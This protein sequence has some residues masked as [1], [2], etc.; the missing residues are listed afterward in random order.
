MPFGKLKQG[1]GPPELENRFKTC[2]EYLRLCLNLKYK[3]RAG[4]IDQWLTLYLRLSVHF[5]KMKTNK[6]TKK[7]ESESL[8]V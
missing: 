1:E 7:K 5:S 4:D 8:E 2:L 6:Q 3:K